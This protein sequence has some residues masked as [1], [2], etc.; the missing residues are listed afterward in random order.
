M[1]LHRKNR[2]W[3][4]RKHQI[5]SRNWESREQKSTSQN[6]AQIKKWRTEINRPKSEIEKAKS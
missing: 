6:Q 3:E 1:A 2:N 5:K 4:S